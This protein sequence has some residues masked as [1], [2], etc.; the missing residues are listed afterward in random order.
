MTIA[1]RVEDYMMQYGVQYD[2]VTHPHS[3]SSAETAELAQVPGDSLAKSV[4]LQ[5]EDG[6]LMA[7]LPFTRHVR[8]G[9]LSQ[10]LNRRFRLATEEEISALFKDCERGAIPPLGSAYGIDTIIDDSLAQQPEIYF[11]AGD[12]ERLIRV[13]REQFMLLMEQAGH[14]RFGHHGRLMTYHA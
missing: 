5:D 6:Y 9:R 11:E 1:H 12:H 7:V 2:V 14:G 3:R 4:V 8:L 13:S 10:E